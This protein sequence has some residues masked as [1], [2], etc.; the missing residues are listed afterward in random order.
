[1]QPIRFDYDKEVEEYRIHSY[2]CENRPVDGL[3]TKKRGA[4]NLK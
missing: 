1:M 3:A 2:E 4:L